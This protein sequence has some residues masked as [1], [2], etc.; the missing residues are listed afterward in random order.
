RERRG[1][2]SGALR[3][4]APGELGRRRI[5]PIVAAFQLQHP[6]VTVQMQLTDAVVDLIAHDFDVAV[7]IGMLADSSLIAREIAPN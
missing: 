7:R 2:V 1:T 4:T 5:A 6:Q 3:I